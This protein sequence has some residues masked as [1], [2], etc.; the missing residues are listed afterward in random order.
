MEKQRS[1]TPMLTGDERR[2]S[3]PF[4]LQQSEDEKRGG[5]LGR[6]RHRW[7]PVGLQALLAVVALAGVY[8]FVSL[9]IDQGNALEY[10]V[11][12]VLLIFAINRIVQAI[13]R[14]KR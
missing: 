14:I 13:K 2:G 11:A 8:L 6:T 10:L 5:P 3:A 4:R 7:R 9:A 12:F 1:N